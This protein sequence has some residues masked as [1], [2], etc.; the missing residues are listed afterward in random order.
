MANLVGLSL[1][2]IFF[3]ALL[4]ACKAHTGTSEASREAD[5]TP[6][7]TVSMKDGFMDSSM[8]GGQ[9]QQTFKASDVTYIVT[10]NTVRLKH[11]LRP[12]IDKLRTRRGLENTLVCAQT[13][14][15]HGL[16]LCGGTS[17]N[18]QHIPL[19][20]AAIFAE[21]RPSLGIASV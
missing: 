20:R 9:G 1:V 4:A 18:A 15:I 5:Y 14:E 3:I 7:V 19:M 8:P 12:M 10:A 2:P 11:D 17:R 13:E 6:R 21:G 16:F